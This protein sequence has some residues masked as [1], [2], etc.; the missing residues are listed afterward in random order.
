MS[1][2]PARS[3]AA[4]SLAQAKKQGRG[5]RGRRA[6]LHF[7]PLEGRQLLA[8]R[9]W[10]GGGGDNLWSTAANWSTDV[11]P[12]A[13]DDLQFPAGGARYGPVNDFSNTAFNSISID[14]PGYTISGNP[15]SLTGG[16]ATSYG[17]GSSTLALDITLLAD[18]TI[19]VASDGTLVV[20]G[21]IGD[22]ANSFGIT[23]QGEGE[24]HLSGSNAFDGLATVSDGLLT[25]SNANALGGAT[26]GTTVSSGATLA[27]AGGI[28][29]AAEP[30]T[31]GGAGFGGVGALWS[32]SGSNTL[33][34]YVSLASDTTIGVESGSQL[35]ID[36]LVTDS[37]GTSSLTKAGGGTLVLAGNN[38]YDG[39]TTIHSGVLRVDGTITSALVLA[40]GT[41]G[42]SGTVNGAGITGTDGGTVNP[43]T[44]GG[45]GILTYANSAG[46]ALP[47]STTFRVDLNGSTVGTGYD[48][49]ALTNG[50]ALFNPNG[51]TLQVNLGYLPAVGTSFQIVSQTYGSPITGRFNGL[52]QF[53]S[54]QA[55]P[56]TFSIGYFNS[57]V[58]LTVT[59]IAPRV[60]TWDGG[61]AD[62]SLWSSPDN[63]VGDVAPS[64]FDSLVF[65]DGAA[66]RTNFNDL[67]A[68][69]DLYSITVGAAGYT[70]QGDAVDLYGDLLTTYSAGTSTVG[71]DLAL[72]STRTFTVAAGGTLIGNG[73]ISGTGFGLTKAGGGT[74]VLGGA[75]AN[76]YTD[77]TTVGEGT[78][79][80]VKTA[81][82]NAVGGRLVLGSPGKTALLKL[83][84]SDQIP[85]GTTVTVGKGSTFHLDGKAET[86]AN[87][88]L[89]GAAA[90]LGAGGTLALTTSLVTSSTSGAFLSEIK[91]RGNLDLAGN[92]A[93]QIT[94]NDDPDLAVDLRIGVTVSNGGIVKLGAGGM[95][96]AGDNTYA[97]TTSV[98]AGI[99]R[100]EGQGAL[101]STAAGTAV[102]SGAS[103][104]FVGSGLLFSE[105]FTLS[106]NGV[107]DLGAL[108]VDSGSATLD[109][110]LTIAADTRL[111]AASGALLTVAGAIGG[112]GDLSIGNG[113]TGRTTLSGD[114]TFR[115]DMDVTSGYL[116]ITHANALGDPTDDS[117]LSV[118]VGASLELSGGVTISAVK[119]I[120]LVGAGADS[121]SDPKLASL[122]GYNI[123]L[124]PITLQGDAVVSVESGSELL[125]AGS[126]GESSGPRGLTK[127]GDGTLVLFA[128]GEYTGSTNIVDGTL[129][130]DG[131][132]SAGGSS[133]VI[134]SGAT[135]E[136][137]GVVGSVDIMAG[138]VVSPGGSSVG[139]LTT[140]HLAA[141]DESFFGYQ[142]DGPTAGIGH[143]QIVVVGE[144]SLGN[145]IFFVSFGYMPVAGDSFTLIDNDGV[146]AVSGAFYGL[147]E[148]RVLNYEGV[149][150]QI[151]Y[152]GGTGNDVVLTVVVI[153]A[154]PS[155]LVT[156]TAGSFYSQQITATAG[157]GTGYVFSATGLPPGLSI[158][159]SGLISGTPTTPGAVPYE[160]TLTIVDS[161]ETSVTLTYFMAVNAPI[162]ASP[163][164][165][166]TPIVGSAYSQQITAGGGSGGG[167]SFS[168][169]GLPDG[170]SIGPDGL[171]SGTPTSTAPA[172]V[173]VTITDCDGATAVVTYSIAAGRAGT[174]TALAVTPGSTIYGQTATLVATIAS[175]AS[176]I[177]D[178]TGTVQFFAGDTLLGV[179]T[180]D[181][182]GVAT[183]TTAVLGGGSGQITAVY[184]GDANYEASTSA[185]AAHEVTRATSTMTLAASAATSNFG[186]PVTLTATIAGQFGGAVGG[187]VSF[188]DGAT[189]LGSAPVGADGTAIFVTSALGTGAHQ[190]TA[191]YGGDANLLGAT[192]PAV[193]VA[194]SPAQTNAGNVTSSEPQVFF[195]QAVILTATFSATSRDGAPMTGTVSF[196]DGD[197]FLGAV[198]LVSPARG[199]LLRTG[200]LADP[201][202]V[203]GQAILPT[204]A[205]GVGMHAIRAVY[206]G[207]AHYSSATSATPVSVQVAPTITSTTLTAST[208]PLGTTLTAVVVV[209]SPGDPTVAGTVSFFDGATLLGSSPVVDGK[210]SLFLGALPSG[211]HA[212]TAV[213]S[214]GGQS[215]ADDSS[216]AV[217]TMGVNGR[218][219]LDLNANG[220]PDPG[221]PGLA[222]RRVFADLNGN[223]AFDAGEPITTTD[224]D[225]G[226]ALPDVAPGSAAIL[227]ATDQDDSRRYVVD[228]TSAGG[229]GSLAIGAVP[230]SPI[231]PVAVV[232]D[233]FG[234]N[235]PSDPDAAYVRSLYRAVL[236]REGADAEVAGWLSFMASGMT[237]DR[238]AE[239]F[240]N[241]PEHRQSQVDAYYRAFLDRGADPSSQFWVDALLTGASEESVVAGIIASPEYQQARQD[242]LS[243]VRDLYLDVL[244]R[245]AEESG[246]AAWTAKLESGMSRRE[247]ESSFINSPEAIDQIVDSYYTA[248]LRRRPDAAA[249]YWV[250]MLGQ[251]DPSATDA[252]LGFLAS[253]EFFSEARRGR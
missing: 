89:E 200:A 64:R 18:S 116:R 209:T 246:L 141:T 166:A 16:I 81:G 92:G 78:L 85:D 122:D 83:G 186:E 105:A 95:A 172:T 121:G 182:L 27:L 188:F 226:F 19:D 30:L 151:S 24:L 167:Y 108:I 25:V 101:G 219:Y 187:T 206:S 194:I 20:S 102:A 184:V 222:G 5:R 233:P 237:R 79:E 189:P 203:S 176:E 138:G 193:A 204:T 100:V 146:D 205:L 112:T 68:G 208:T 139:I 132:I 159:A 23:K 44:V 93:F 58:T 249:S 162:V 37:F 201:A 77:L 153:Q 183:L 34:N 180:L 227:E 32:R 49:L 168:A 38:D 6:P 128:G 234:P 12:S 26:Y 99:L 8:T 69:F 126:I 149:P 54:F 73:A 9:I 215:S 197:V 163:T 71:L 1:S 86:V 87:L 175:D 221:E 241:S 97:G 84:A 82:V 98:N 243:Y 74:L 36:D 133:V 59:S 202:I 111:G 158:S 230:Y 114:N 55:G 91:G 39:S 124:G 7:E 223:A 154:Q 224:A 178:P 164:T 165:L 196:F 14:D 212:F 45:P 148:G 247:V 157:S 104:V 236:G 170:L 173:L 22:G 150:I 145:A 213:F 56:A 235:P 123:V 244:G 50:S 13:N 214:N 129:R 10:D 94:V 220:V 90:D 147:P 29:L 61:D 11:A 185:A 198:D 67:G 76:T 88:V 155:T 248:F 181:E 250:D 199:N 252:A 65:P 96:L 210:A 251:P 142:I 174:T 43:G 152:I 191:V 31:V 239:G 134:G 17:P 60:L 136:G 118:A 242:N 21:V 75:A 192:S 216:S 53:G 47:S 107:S 161:L 207:D 225:G 238:V 117:V 228:Q 115:G 171:I 51:A 48:R 195:G 217:V 140:G 177:G 120:V 63:W 169:T 232:P 15:L 103:I 229:D 80:L 135:L 143:D 240:W 110:M 57:G 40:G 41:L 127:R 211:P 144:V 156:P 113:T 190:I 72:Q 245:R 3:Q 253:E 109:G 137:T 42:G 70:L 2:R 106:G 66:R 130:V 33:T 131:D 46:F 35:T 28:T 119:S 160:V 218:V 4:R 52:S 125:F 62:D 179:A 231:A